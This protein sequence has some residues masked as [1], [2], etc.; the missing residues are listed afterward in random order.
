VTAIELAKVFEDV[1]LAA[2]I[3]TDIDR[4]GV[5]SG[6]NIAATIN[7]ARGVSTPVIASGGISSIADLH[8]LKNA[9]ED[10]LAG[11]ISG[12]AIYDGVIDPAKAVALLR[13]GVDA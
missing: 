9:G 10:F 6:P 8:A 2:I 7:L 4:D 12:R 11:I 3:Y 13:G 5:M 1:D